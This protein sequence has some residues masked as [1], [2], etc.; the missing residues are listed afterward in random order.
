MKRTNNANILWTNK[1]CK[2][3]LKAWATYCVLLEKILE[4][5]RHIEHFAYC[6]HK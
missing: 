3:L 5:S 6:P 1:I 2:T 4:N